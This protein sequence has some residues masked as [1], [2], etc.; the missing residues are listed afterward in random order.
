MAFLYPFIVFLQPVVLWP[1]LVPYRPLMLLSLVAAIFALMRTGAAAQW[2]TRLR[3]PIFIWMCVFVILQPV[4]VYYGGVLGMLDTLNFW[5][6]YASFVA[7][8]LLLVRDLKQLYRYLAGVLIGCAV[9]IGYGLYAVATHSPDLPGNRAGAYGMYQ[10][11]NDY[12][13]II[14]MSLP[15][16]YMCL[17]IAKGWLVRLFLMAFVLA[18]IIGTVLSL[19]R[20]GIIGLVLMLA[21]LYWRSTSGAK[22]TIGVLLL[23][24]VGSVGIVWQFAAREENQKG[25]YSAEDAKNSRYELWRAAR[26]IVEK[27]PILGIGS[28]RYSEKARQYAE[29]SHDQ[30]G[31]VSHN[32]YLEV[33]T[34]SGFLGFISFMA[35]LLGILKASTEKLGAN[36]SGIPP[37]VRA[38]T[39]IGI[40]TIMLRAMLDAKTYDWSFYFLAVIAILVGT[41]AAAASMTSATDAVPDAAME[42][43]NG[44]GRRRLPAPPVQARPMVYGRRA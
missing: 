24:G 43:Q 19:S 14:L 20:G 35:M 34:G 41:T 30:I 25:N 8:S 23:V 31:K 12:T 28:G 40:F 42:P 16:A 39:Q 29:L 38:A 26:K 17:R 15:Y 1:A 18:C 21:L 22:R 13:F 5:L 4:S 10:N 44:S 9:V 37:P 6:T 32:T 11:H 3:H 33:L 27:H 36:R 7:V 2:I